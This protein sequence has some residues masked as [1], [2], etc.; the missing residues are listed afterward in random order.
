MK[1]KTKKWITIRKKQLTEIKK[2]EITM[3]ERELT[4]CRICEKQLE[5]RFLKQ[6][7]I[8]CKKA[9]DLKDDLKMNLKDINNHLLYFC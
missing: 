9:E 2:L 5:M 3:A 7:S 1:W 4:I 6:H 8:L